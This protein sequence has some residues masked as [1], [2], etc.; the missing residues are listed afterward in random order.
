MELSTYSGSFLGTA[1]VAV[2]LGVSWL[3]KNKLKHSKCKL[4]S[5]C[6]QISS[7][8]DSLRNTVR[9]EILE[10]L[11]RDGV[12]PRQAMEGEFTEV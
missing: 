7:Q 2:I 1:T 9:L 8:E 6:L 11:R 10:E 12:I 3:C 5:K 4:D